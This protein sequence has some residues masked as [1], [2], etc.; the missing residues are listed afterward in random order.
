MKSNVLIIQAVPVVAAEGSAEGTGQSWQ[1]L[2]QSEIIT[3]RQWRENIIILL[4]IILITPWKSFSLPI[5]YFVA[6]KF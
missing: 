5:I 4:S 6:I 3:S 1:E 2:A